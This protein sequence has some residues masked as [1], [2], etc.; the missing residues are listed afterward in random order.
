LPQKAPTFIAMLV[1]RDA[2]EII[3]CWNLGKPRLYSEG[4][5]MEPSRRYLIVIMLQAFCDLG[6]CGLQGYHLTDGESHSI[7]PCLIEKSGHNQASDKPTI[8]R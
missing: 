1:L 2:M 4:S 8:L 5:Q 7:L 6:M 3:Q